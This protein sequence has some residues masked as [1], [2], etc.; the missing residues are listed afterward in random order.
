MPKATKINN[1]LY[2]QLPA[3]LINALGITDGEE[4]EFFRHNDRSFV[5]AKKKEL[6]NLLEGTSKAQQIPPG[7]RQ[8]DQSAIMDHESL[9]VLKKL[10]TL[11][12]G[13]RTKERVDQLLTDAEKKVLQRL[14]SGKVV[15]LYRKDPKEQ[16]KYSIPR[17]I[18]NTFLFGKRDYPQRQQAVQPVA[19]KP[20]PAVQ[21]EKKRWDESFG[22][23]YLNAIETDGYLVLRTESDASA[24]SSELEES[25]K[26]GLIVGTRAFDKKFYICMKGFVV[27]NAPRITKLL[28]SGGAV[29]LTSLSESLKMEPD[30][31]RAILYIMAESGEV[32]EVRKDIFRLVT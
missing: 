3:E 8:S 12:Y 5:V 2:V 4:L 6:L 29:P 24:A 19:Q 28:E 32:S 25:I 22:Q 13:E 20:A 16:F 11:R 27:K 21:Q 26:R 1:R 31:I 9:D 30:A 15:E 17:D 18:Y 14:V 7:K 23:G 10:D